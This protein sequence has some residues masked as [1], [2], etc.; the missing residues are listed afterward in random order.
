MGTFTNSE[1]PD[2][3]QHNALCGISS[4]STGSAVAQW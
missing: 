4:G 2:E 1:E 3:M